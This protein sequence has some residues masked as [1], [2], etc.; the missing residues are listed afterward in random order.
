MV[1]WQVLGQS[2]SVTHWGAHVSNAPTSAGADATTVVAA[3]ITRKFLVNFID[4]G[5][6]VMIILV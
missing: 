4:N 5:V 2:L 6:G 1:F 3:A